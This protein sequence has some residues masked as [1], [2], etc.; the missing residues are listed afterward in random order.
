VVQLGR[1]RDRL[2]VGEAADGLVF[3]VVGLDLLAHRL[4]V[5]DDADPLALLDRLLRL[6]L[7]LLL[8]PLDATAGGVASVLERA[9]ALLHLDHLLP[10]ETAHL[11]LPVQVTHADA[12]QLIVADEYRRRAQRRLVI[13][14]PFIRLHG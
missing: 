3:L 7:V 12:D 14:F 6:Q 2:L 10:A 8:Q 13:F 5:L 1:Q 4:V 9:S 11:E